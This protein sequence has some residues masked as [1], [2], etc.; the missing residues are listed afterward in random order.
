MDAHSNID[1][2]TYCLCDFVQVVHSPSLIFNSKMEIIS[3]Y[4][5]IRVSINIIGFY[6][7]PAS[8]FPTGCSENLIMV[9]AVVFILNQALG[10]HFTCGL[11]QLE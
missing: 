5:I 1:S 8:P 2:Y 3:P 6:K 10:K 7:A 11:R 4:L 9:I